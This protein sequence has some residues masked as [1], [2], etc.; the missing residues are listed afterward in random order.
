MNSVPV[1]VGSLLAAVLAVVLVGCA[2]Q[3]PASVPISAESAQSGIVLSRSL[4]S[5]LPEK[6]V[7]VPHS[8]F[9]LIPSESAVGMLVPIPFLSGAIAGV[10]DRSA[11]EAF[12]A[13]YA[14][15]AP[16]KIALAEMQKSALYQTQGGGLVLQPYLFMTE[17]IDDTYRLAMVF[18]VEGGDW[19]GRY[20]YHLPTAYPMS[21]FRAPSAALLG[22]LEKEL[23]TCARVLR[24][25]V[26]SGARGELASTGAKA[27]IGSLHLVGGRAG[28]LISPMAMI[29]KEADLLRDSGD[30][31]VVRM[32]GD[33]SK[34]GTAGGLFIGVHY[35][36]KD[37]LHTFKRL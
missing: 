16:Y 31:V 24:Q 14:S 34:P 3:P 18:Q 17:C 19:M 32:A 35:F 9:V 12:D 36:R 8:Q 22:T 2:S 27:D 25:L 1:S 26:E 4:P 30:T 7:P 13:R 15:I 10:M 11:A 20:M 5:V 29:A 23:A 28:G 6:A 21:D 33:V 37:Q